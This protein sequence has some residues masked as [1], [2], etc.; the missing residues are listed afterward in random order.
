MDEIRQVNDREISPNLSKQFFLTFTLVSGIDSLLRKE[1]ET[2]GIVAFGPRG[3]KSR[4][5]VKDSFGFKLSKTFLT[6]N[7]DALGPK[8]QR[9]D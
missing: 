6:K 3:G 8:S 1:N 9:F 5:L 4:K 2:G 7:S